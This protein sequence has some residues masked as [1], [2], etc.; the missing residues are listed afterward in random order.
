MEQRRILAD[1]SYSELLSLLDWFHLHGPIL[2]ITGGWVVFF[3]NSYLGSVDIDPVGPSMGGLFDNTLEV[4][5]CN[6]GYQA[7]AL[8]R[9]GLQ[10]S[11]RKPIVENGKI[12]I[13]RAT[14]E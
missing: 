11:F 2:L 7:V 10:T 8:D 4:F 1:H 9:L 3:Y 6:Q 13:A 12:V 14:C 5:E